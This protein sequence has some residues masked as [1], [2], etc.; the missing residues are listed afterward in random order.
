[1]QAQMNALA[2]RHLSTG[3]V[4]ETCVRG[5]SQFHRSWPGS[6]VF[7]SAASLDVFTPRIPPVDMPQGN[8]SA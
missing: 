1:M 3:P 6:P 4:I 8:N 7:E 2:I 5:S